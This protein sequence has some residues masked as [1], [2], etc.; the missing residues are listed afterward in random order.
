LLYFVIQLGVH[1]KQVVP[2]K[3]NEKEPFCFAEK[4]RVVLPDEGAK[5]CFNIPKYESKNQKTMT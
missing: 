3:G 5:A 2:G 1:V 4:G